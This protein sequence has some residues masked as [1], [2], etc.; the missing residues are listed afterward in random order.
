MNPLGISFERPSLTKIDLG[1]GDYA[2]RCEGYIESRTLGRRGYYEG[3]CD[4]LDQFF[5][6][7]PGWNKKSG[8][9][10][11]RKSAATNWMVNAVSRIGG[12]RDP[13]PVTL[14]AAGLDPDKIPIVDY[15]SRKHPED[16]AGVIS[17]AQAKRL[18][19]ICK[20]NNVSEEAL[21]V[22]LWNAGQWKSTREV[23][24]GKYDAL[25]AWAQAGGQEPPRNRANG[26]R[27]PG[28]EG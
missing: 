17:E 13:D 10:D 22:K 4:S 20:S 28:E 8:E 14:R 6:A 24:R 27:E 18:W 2:Y 12:I 16:D 3:Y 11:I 7:R 5:T 21:R 15:K 23:T 1:N 9:G 25:C 26:G 19:A